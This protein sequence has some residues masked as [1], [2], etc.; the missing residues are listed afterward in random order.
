MLDVVHLLPPHVLL[1]L[2][3]LRGLKLCQLSRVADDT[4]RLTAL[5]MLVHLPKM[6]LWPL[7]E[8]NTS[9]SLPLVQLEDQ[10][11]AVEMPSS[12]RVSRGAE[13]V[14]ET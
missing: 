6:Y 3:A 7:T 4:R 13:N 11:T 2:P 8:I 1:N 14:F 5:T 9:L 10:S 12:Y